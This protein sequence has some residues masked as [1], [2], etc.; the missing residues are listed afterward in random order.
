MEGDSYLNN[1]K[2]MQII[3]EYKNDDIT[4]IDAIEEL[5]KLGFSSKEAE[6]IISGVDDARE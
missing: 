6:D 5:E 2:V 1:P 4:Y 3:I